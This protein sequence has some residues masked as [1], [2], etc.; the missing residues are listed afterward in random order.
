M[1]PDGQLMAMSSPHDPRGCPCGLGR[2]RWPRLV[3]QNEFFLKWRLAMFCLCGGAPCRQVVKVHVIRCVPVKR[4]MRPGLVVKRQV[5]FQCLVSSADGLVGVEIHLLVFDALPEAFYEYV[6]AP[7]AFPIHADLDAVVFQQPGEFEAGELA[8]LIGVDD[9]RGTRGGQRL[10]DRFETEVGGQRIGQP[11]R[12]H[13]TA[14][15]IQDR[16]QV[17]EAPAHRNVGDIRR[18]DVIGACDLPLVQERGVDRVGG[19]PLAG[20]GLAIYGLNAH[21]S[22]Q[23]GHVPPPN[24]MAVSPQ[25]VAQHPGASKRM[26]QMQLVDPAP[27]GQ[28]R[29]RH[30]RRL[31]EYAVDRESARSWHCR[32][33]G[34]AWLRAIIAL[35]S[36][37]PP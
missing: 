2:Q 24:R 31:G 33:T 28:I 12:Q 25:E 26:V 36:A 29:C 11:P 16:T 34:R 20:A 4:P 23:R 17:H 30:R 5:A 19:M 7:A 10:L 6:V 15:P 8:T 21:A 37:R 35:R 22:H 18:P 14:G 32:T 3:G 13:P 27:Q 9:L 1:T